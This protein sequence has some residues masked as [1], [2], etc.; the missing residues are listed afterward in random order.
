MK[1]YSAKPSDIE[2]PWFVIDAE[3]RIVSRYEGTITEPELRADVAA[4][5]GE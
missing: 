4:L 5:L 2:K 3:G 1:T